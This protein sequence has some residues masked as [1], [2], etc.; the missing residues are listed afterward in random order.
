MELPRA[1]KDASEHIRKMYSTI[2]LEKRTSIRARRGHLFGRIHPPGA[3]LKDER[4]EVDL[5]IPEFRITWAGKVVSRLG[6]QLIGT[7]SSEDGSFLWGFANPSVDGHGAERIRALLDRDD[8]LRALASE[9]RFL[10]SADTAQM[11]AGAITLELDAIGPYPGNVGVATAYLAVD[12]PDDKSPERSSWCTFCGGHQ[13]K[14]VAAEI[15]SLCGGPNCYQNFRDIAEF[16]DSDS[17]AP[18][19]D[20]FACVFCGGTKQVIQHRYVGM[21]KECVQIAGASLK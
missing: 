20:D 18:C 17:A 7:H 16:M 3:L 1:G 9:P 15:V 12:L 13:A 10:L 6:V 21:C 5:S 19:P 2:E 8:Q 14:R 4:W 11:L